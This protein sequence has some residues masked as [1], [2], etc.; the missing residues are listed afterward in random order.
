MNN[1]PLSAVSEIN[2]VFLG[3][4]SSVN[5]SQPGERDVGAVWAKKSERVPRG[6]L[7][8]DPNSLKRNELTATSVYL[9]EILCNAG[10][11]RWSR[12]FTRV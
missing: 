5:L 12:V 7:L 4:S 8:S 9:A 1:W 10:D 11:K 6:K 2:I 3:F